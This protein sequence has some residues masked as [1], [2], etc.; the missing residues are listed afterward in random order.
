M[1]V[2]LWKRVQATS[3]WLPDGAAIA[4]RTAAYVWGVELADEDDPIEVASATRLRNGPGLL[5]RTI[6]VRPAEVTIH[7]GVRLTTPL[8]TAWELARALPELDAIGWVDALARRRRLTRKE[9]REHARSH[10]GEYGSRAATST[11]ECADPRA[12][13]PPESRLRLSLLRAGLPVPVPQFTVLHDGFFVARV[14]LAWPAYRL[15]VEYDGQW[16]ADGAQLHRDRSRLRD[17]L[18]AGWYVYPVTREDMRDISLLTREIGR[19]LTE[20][21]SLLE[22]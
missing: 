19:I 21:R 18:A 4:G 17:L 13:S 3:L 10:W 8:H 14:D 9:F 7:R 20:R 1:P 15:A 5:V 6:V 11:L 16:H 2:T 22:G 12:E